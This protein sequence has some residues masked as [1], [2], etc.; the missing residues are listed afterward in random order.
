MQQ[1]VTIS[2]YQPENPKRKTTAVELAWMRWSTA[3]A[4]GTLILSL[5]LTRQSLWIDE[6]FTALIVSQHSL[7]DMFG[8]LGQMPGSDAQLSGYYSVLWVWVRAFGNSEFALR[9]INLVGAGILSAALYWFSERLLSH[10]RGWLVACAAPF[11]FFY[12][13]EARPYMLVLAFACLAAASLLTAFE[14]PQAKI[15]A[16]IFVLSVLAMWFLHM[17]AI[18]AVPGL[19]TVGILRAR[20]KGYKAFQEIARASLILSPFFLVLGVYYAGTLVRG[21]KGYVQTPGPGNLAFALFEFAGMGG[22]GPPRDI[23]RLDPS[24]ALVASYWPTLT[25]GLLGILGMLLLGFPGRRADMATDLIA[26]FVVALVL[27]LV[28]ARITDFRFLGRHLAALFPLLLLAML[29]SETGP[30]WRRTV[31]WIVIAAAW[32]VSDYRLVALPAYAKDDTRSAVAYAEEQVMAGHHVVWVGEPIAPRYYGLDLPSFSRR[33]RPET[34]PVRFTVPSG[35]LWSVAQI[36][37]EV[38]GHP[39]LLVLMERPDI[40]DREHHWAEACSTHHARLIAHFNSFGVW[41]FP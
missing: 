39:F 8:V 17:L 5:G 10:A 22:L 33:F 36:D 28:A 15:S 41:S 37:A 18:F 25:I 19:V 35:N 2:S 34:F 31:A 29:A 24:L 20:K 7:S 1:S 30:R 32:S 40:V 16:W 11:A 21:A 38:E 13:N 9:A 4:A 12:M 6:G 23:L 14:M 26:G 27:F 3:I